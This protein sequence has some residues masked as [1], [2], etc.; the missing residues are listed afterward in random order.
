MEITNTAELKK[1]LEERNWLHDAQVT[2]V[3]SLLDHSESDKMSPSSSVEVQRISG[4]YWAGEEE[5]FERSK[6]TGYGVTKWNCSNLEE[7]LD[8]SIGC[9]DIAE[10]A[11]LLRFCIDDNLTI[12]CRQLVIDRI[13]LQTSKVRPSLSTREARVRVAGQNFINPPEWIDLFEQVDVSVGFRRLGDVLVAVNDVPIDYTGWFLQHSDRVADTKCGLMFSYATVKDGDFLVS[14]EMW[15][16]SEDY[17][18]P[19][20]DALVRV[21]AKLPHSAVRCGN[22]R[23]SGKEWLLA[24]ENGDEWL[25]ERFGLK[26]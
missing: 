26:Q 3:S 24:L 7:I 10:E 20:W 18:A 21:I 1:W 22:C 9:A 12:E 19:L 16:P 14:F 25:M 11:E 2:N 13:E 17:A 23:F 4:S 8:Y 6:I 15:S 5:T